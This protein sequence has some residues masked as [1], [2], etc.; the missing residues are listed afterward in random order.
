L[1]HD[2][3]QISQVHDFYD[4]YLRK[5]DPVT[6]WHYYTE[7]AD[8]ISLSTITSGKNFYMLKGLSPC[9][10]TLGQIWSILTESKRYLTTCVCA[11]SYGLTL[12][13]EQAE[14]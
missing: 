1:Q 5:Y 8:Y 9:I 6:R 12:K 11:T 14:A 7:I 3:H 4:K 13:I 10:Q 2:C